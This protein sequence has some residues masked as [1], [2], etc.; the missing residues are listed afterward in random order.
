V[1]QDPERRRGWPE[2]WLRERF[3]LT[4]AYLARF[5]PVL[6]RRAMYRR[7]FPERGRGRGEA[8]APFYSMFDVGPYSFSAWKVVW[9]GFGT[10]TRQAAVAGPVGG[11]PVMPNQAMHPF[12]ATASGDEAHYLCAI[13]NASP[14]EAALRAHTQPGG[15]SFAQPGAVA[16][17]R[18]PRFEP[19]CPAHLALAELSRQAHA[20]A[21]GDSPADLP[22]LEREIDAHAASLWNL[23]PAELAALDRLL[24]P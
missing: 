9:A 8:G 10:R 4:W 24:R 15:K 14:V 18:L 20:A 16:R 11:R 3:P 5:E 23:S 19:G 7:Y 17:L 1:T 22:A 12:I 2:E 21:A 6:R 13:L